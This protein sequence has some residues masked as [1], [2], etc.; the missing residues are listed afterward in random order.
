M[1]PVSGSLMNEPLP[2]GREAFGDS[3]IFPLSALLAR[4]VAVGAMTRATTR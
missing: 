2:P 1:C 3:G 4:Y